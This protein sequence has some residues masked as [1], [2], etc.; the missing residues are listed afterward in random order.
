MASRLL[1]VVKG[2]YVARKAVDDLLD[3]LRNESAERQRSRRARTTQLKSEERIRGLILDLRGNPGGLLK[4]AV[5]VASLFLPGEKEIVSTRDRAGEDFQ[6]FTAE[7]E[8]EHH[9]ALP[10]VVLVNGGSASASEI[11]SGAL[12]VHKRALVVGERTFGKG[13]VQQVLPVD[14]RIG[15]QAAVA[16]QTPQS[17]L[18]R[19][20]QPRVG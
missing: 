12:Q 1:A 10:M 7:P 17:R 19:P 9:L 3:R 6:V 8:G 2:V 4:T 13:S 18:P 20:R 16:N 11:V 14:G 5:E 15:G